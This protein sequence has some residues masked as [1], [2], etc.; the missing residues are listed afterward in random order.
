[1]PQ[2]I[3]LSYLRLLINVEEKAGQPIIAFPSQAAFEKW[4]AK[5]H[6]S[7]T[8][9]W[10]K[11]GKKGNPEPSITYAEAVEAGL[12]YGWIDGQ[13]A[14]YDELWFLQRFTPR[15]RQS[16]WSKVNRDKVDALVAAGRMQPSGLREVEAAKAD[17]RWERAYS[18]Q[19]TAKV[20]DD[21]QAALDQNKQAADAF[22]TLRASDRYAILYRVETAKR[23]E[24]RSRRIAQF[25]EM[26]A[27]G[28]TLNPVMPPKAR[29]PKGTK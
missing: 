11:I 6:T 23:A 5:N 24:T 19:A 27:E 8:G 2:W 7:T 3:P 29:P 12:I 15:R 18:G 9:F 1:M 25:V 10:M 20:P 17:G 13:K 4:L 28:R 16:Q 26:L 22:Q 14:A 21:L